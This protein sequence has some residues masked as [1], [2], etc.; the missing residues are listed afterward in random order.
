[1]WFAKN[2]VIYAQGAACDAVFHIQKG[3]VRL[4]VVAKNG[5]DAII[6]I[7]DSGEFFGEVAWQDGLYAWGQQSR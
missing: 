7:L 2:Q 1:M 3:K 5:K 4:S 6:G